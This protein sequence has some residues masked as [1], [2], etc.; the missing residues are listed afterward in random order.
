MMGFT[1]LFTLFKAGDP[2][3]GST[4]LGLFRKTLFLRLCLYFSRFLGRLGWQ[5]HQRQCYRLTSAVEIG[6][7]R[8][9]RTSARKR[10]IVLSIFSLHFVGQN[11]LSDCSV[12]HIFARLHEINDESDFAKH[13]LCLKMC[14]QTRL[15]I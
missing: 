9:T 10:C 2:S 6:S 14:Q 13:T 12:R 5:S 4:P 7:S 1:C 3:R 15:G 8:P 11:S